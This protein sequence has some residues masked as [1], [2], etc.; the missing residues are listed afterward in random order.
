M[1]WVKLDVNGSHPL[2]IGAYYKPNEDD[3]E[4]LLELRKSLE[5]V[6]SRAK[7]NAWALGGF[8][9]PKLDYTDNIPSFKPN[10]TLRP[11]Y[12]IS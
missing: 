10:C 1:I 9:L 7:G 5:M 8:Y 3:Q 2:L 11:T 4:S 6:K 12:L